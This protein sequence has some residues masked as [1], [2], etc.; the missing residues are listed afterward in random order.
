MNNDR[1]AEQL[2]DGLTSEQ[3]A[4]LLARLLD[5]VSETERAALCDELDPD[6]AAVFGRVLKPP[7]ADTTPNETPLLTSDAKFAEQF[8]S[9]LENLEGL[10]VELGDEDGDYVFQE[11]DWE[12]PD[13]DA[14]RLA[15]DI[16]RC[17]KELLPLLERAAEL[18]LEG[19][20]LFLDLCQ[21]ISDGIGLYPD[22]IYTEEG[23]EL[24]Q[25]AT[26]CTLK[27]LDL[28]SGTEAS[29]LGRLSAFM[30]EA[31]CVGLDG[32]MIREYLLK[33]WAA[34][35]RRALYDAIQARRSSDDT[36]RGQVDKPRTL[37]YDIRYALA[38]EFDVAGKIRIAE[39]SVAE[40]WTKGVGLVD[41]ALAVGDSARALGF[42]RK[43]VD[44]YYRS[45]SFG[46]QS[47]D[48]DPA[49]T[50][51][52]SHRGM[53]GESP[54]VSRVLGLWADLSAK[55][56]DVALA[57]LLRI[58]EALFAAPDDRTAGQRAFAQV[59]S[60][61]ASILF[62]AWKKRTLEQQRG[63]YLLGT[64]PQ[65][66]VWPEWLID[67]GFADRFGAFTEKAVPWLSEKIEAEKKTTRDV[68]RG[69]QAFRWPPQM[70]LTA[71]LFALEAA[72][73]EYRTLNDMLTQ[74]C[75][76][77]DCPARLE[78]LGKTDVA[79][80]TAAAVGFVRTNMARLI[81]SPAH[82]GGDYKLA[83]GWLAAAREIAPG[84]ARS[85]LQHWRAEYKRR[86]NLWRDLRAYGFDV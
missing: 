45:R 67:A 65:G 53:R 32:S 82:M 8:Q 63:I 43:T 17:A 58:Q 48:F 23:V 86:R 27:W 84:T 18:G 68:F 35:R 54:L 42:C 81:P 79:K 60:A 22:H 80:L 76:L 4:G 14:S 36:F 52:F 15:S 25:V 13:F 39:A 3:L 59:H 62:G 24:D 47:P 73:V 38:G 10:L 41:A 56:G 12:P 64:V 30:D 49:T 44:A 19:E 51:L 6:V 61:D 71:D 46:R 77:R 66:S 31:G 26:E 2:I 20:G 50:P 7:P 16:G 28:H 11:H 72:P 34:D 5:G 9:M 33:R 21:E 40:D 1:L 37:W 78:W 70:S 69:H 55:D 85:T 29:F 75:R 57:E 83:T 74:N